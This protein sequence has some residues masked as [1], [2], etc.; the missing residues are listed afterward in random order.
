MCRRWPLSSP[1]DRQR[2]CL[3]HDDGSSSSESRRG[4]LWRAGRLQPEE[5]HQ[6]ERVAA[7][8]YAKDDVRDFALWK[9]TRD[10]ERAG[11]EIGAGRPGLHIECSAMS[12]KYLGP[13]FDI[14]TAASIWSFSSP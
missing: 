14:H 3:S 1:P 4:R 13:T 5:L 11:H 9:A 7:D 8:D 2:S 6:G 10:G 12:M